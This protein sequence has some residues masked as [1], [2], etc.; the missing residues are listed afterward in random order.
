MQRWSPRGHPWPRGHILNHLCLCPWSLTSNIL[1]L[2]V[3]RA[4]PQKGCPGLRIFLYPWPR[5][6]CPLLQLWYHVFINAII[7]GVK[8][9]FEVGIELEKRVKSVLLLWFASFT[10][11][12]SGIG[13]FNE[14]LGRKGEIGLAGPVPE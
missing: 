9:S 12:F 2:G 8:V 10:L 7:V 6:L 13:L 11:L 1:V 3:E 14:G 4:C 5:V